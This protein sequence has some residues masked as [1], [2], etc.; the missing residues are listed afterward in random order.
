MSVFSGWLANSGFHRL[1]CGNRKSVW[2]CFNGK[3]FYHAWGRTKFGTLLYSRNLIKRLWEEEEVPSPP[4]PILSPE[5]IECE[6]FYKE[7]FSLTVK[8][9]CSGRYIVHLPLQ[10]EEPSRL[11][12]TIK[13]AKRSLMELEKHLSRTSGL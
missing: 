7:I 3:S 6:I 4:K 10:E 11:G 9:H 12:Q 1:T 2:A 8:R 13:V 5:D